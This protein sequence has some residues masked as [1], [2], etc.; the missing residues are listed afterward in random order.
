MTDICPYG[1]DYQVYWD[2]RYQLF[3]RFDQTK[4]DRVGLYTMIAE[5]FATDLA[6][7]ATGQTSIDACS[8]MGAM[9]IALAREGQRVIAI[10]RDEQRVSMAR[11]NA[12]VYEVADQIDF[13]VGDI[14]SDEVIDALPA[15]NHTLFIDPPWGSGPGDYLRR[16][17]TYLEHLSLGGVDMRWLVS[18]VP[19]RELMIRFPPNFDVDIF[20]DTPGE[21]IAIVNDAGFLHWYFLRTSP[22]AFAAVPDRSR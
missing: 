5:H 22:E 16:P 10:E 4:V 11:H 14:T 8:G 12:A 19:C 17:T 13:R 1:P 2:M 18:R 9:S 20:I 7:K 21:K 15:D 3:S 6:K